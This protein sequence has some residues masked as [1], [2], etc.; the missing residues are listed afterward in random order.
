MLTPRLFVGPMS[1]E[2]VDIVLDYSSG[3]NCLGLIPSRRQIEHDGG[4]VNDWATLD[5]ANHVK[6]SQKN[7]LLVRDHGGPGQG[8]VDDDGSLSLIVDIASGFHILHM[9]LGRLVVA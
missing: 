7:V 6:K 4:Y 1:K 5:F 2:I 9:I 8:S 3:N